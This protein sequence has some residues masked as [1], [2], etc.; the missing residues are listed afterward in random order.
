MRRIASYSIRNAG[1]IA[2]NLMLANLQNFASDWLTLLCALNATI[3]VASSPSSVV[4]VPAVAFAST[5]MTKKVLLS[6]TIPLAPLSCFFV[7]KVALRSRFAH[8][9]VNMG[10]NLALSGT[11][12][13]Q[14]SLVVAGANGGAAVALASTAGFLVGK[15]MSSSNN[16]V[17]AVQ[18]LAAELDKLIPSSLNEAAFRRQCAIN[19]FYKLVLTIQSSLPANLVSAITP[20][21]RAPSSGHQT[22]Q[23]PGDPTTNPI[24][25]PVPKLMEQQQTAGQT[26]YSADEPE[27]PGTLYAAPVYSTVAV[28]PIVSV[29]PSAALGM[30]GVVAFFSARDLKDPNFK[31][32]VTVQ[33][34]PL[35]ASDSV[36]CA[37]QLIG[38]VVAEDQLLADMGSRLVQVT[39]GTAS[40]PILTIDDAIAANSFYTGMPGLNVPI[41]VGDVNKAFAA[42]D[43]VIEGQSEMGSQIH[44]HM[45]P[46]IFYSIP[47]EAGTL[48]VIGAFQVSTFL[49]LFS[50]GLNEKKKKS[51]NNSFSK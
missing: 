9:L 35:F 40:T 41:V 20:F 48:K 8:A 45:E 31:W 29:D 4:T 23:N 34:E 19:L 49:L 50:S 44:F 11:V 27:L 47:Q 37:G 22:Y 36:V 10:A 17:Q 25:Y 16:F 3:Q 26:V 5:D 6:I 15:D 24:S 2:G 7:E 21:K 51:F 39:Y 14:A 18:V 1:S 28:A 42:S 46:Q 32:G 13:T 33:D 30:E 12:V 38:L 43:V